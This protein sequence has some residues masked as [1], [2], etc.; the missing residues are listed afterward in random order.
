MRSKFGLAAIGILSA[1][2][3][4]PALAAEESIKTRASE[5]YHVLAEKEV[6]LNAALKI[7][8]REALKNEVILPLYDLIGKLP[9]A[10]EYLE[11]P[12][13]GCFEAVDYLRNAAD[14]FDGQDSADRMVA[15]KE[16]I[17]NYAEQIADCE[18]ALKIK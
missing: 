6:I 16:Y 2:F 12:Y 15:R 9:P 14:L 5:V 17:V 4:E 7:K 11:T 10:M 13:A 18:I 8:D 1:I 3:C